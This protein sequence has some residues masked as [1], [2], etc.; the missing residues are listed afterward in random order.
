MQ[1]AVNVVYDALLN[2][3]LL[4]SHHIVGKQVLQLWQA[5][6]IKPVYVAVNL[7]QQTFFSGNTEYFVGGYGQMAGALSTD[8]IQ[9]AAVMLLVLQLVPYGV[10]LIQNGVHPSGFLQCQIS[11]VAIPDI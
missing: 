7:S 6:G 9:S 10:Y 8:F 3:M 2:Q 4:A 11:N 1:H 5:T